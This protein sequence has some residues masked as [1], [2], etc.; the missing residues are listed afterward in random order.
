MGPIKAQT[1]AQ[2]VQKQGCCKMAGQC[3]G[4]PQ[5]HSTLESQAEETL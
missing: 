2:A 3:L 4:R 5:A 1:L